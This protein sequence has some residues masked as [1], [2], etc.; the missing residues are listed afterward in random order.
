[1]QKKLEFRVGN[2]SLSLEVPPLFINF[3]KRNF[4]SIMARKRSTETGILA[5]IYITRRHHIQKL[6]ILKG[7]HPDLFM[8]QEQGA[9]KKMISS[10]EIEEFIESIEALEGSWVYKGKGRWLRRFG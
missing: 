4:S 2:S 7:I 6:L 9:I 1:M 5:C 10:T 8:P 3:D